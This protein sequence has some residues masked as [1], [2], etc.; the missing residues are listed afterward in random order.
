LDEEKNA[1]LAFNTVRGVDSDVV[2][3]QISVLD[4]KVIQNLNVPARDEYRD[5]VK[6]SEQQRRLAQA[7]SRLGFE[8]N[9]PDVK[10]FGTYGMNGRDANASEAMTEANTTDH[11][12]Y[13]VGVRL[14]IP[15][16]IGTQS[17]VRKGYRKEELAADYNYQQKVFE[18]ERL[19]KDLTNQFNDSLKRYQMAKVIEKAQ[20]ESMD[21]ERTRHRRGL[22]TTFQ[23]LQFEQNFANAQLARLRA[24]AYV[25]NIYSQLKT[26]GGGHQ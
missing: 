7:N 23:V 21:Y 17:D 22:T 11:P 14:D 4:E 26:F 20:R 12:N 3:E 13:T 2:A 1:S 18:Q 5:D 25:L 15:L 8:K 9:K 24:Q 6:A 10:V 19:W 16:D